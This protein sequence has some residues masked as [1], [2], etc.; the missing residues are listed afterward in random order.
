MTAGAYGR[1]ADPT[2]K[3]FCKPGGE[4]L[5]EAPVFAPGLQKYVQIAL[6]SDRYSVTEQQQLSYMCAEMQGVSSK[7]RVPRGGVISII[8]N[9]QTE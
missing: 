1:L 2:C 7:M 5:H 8:T 4:R 3:V 9:E 6:A